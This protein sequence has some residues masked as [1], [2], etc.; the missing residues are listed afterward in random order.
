MLPVR[1]DDDDDHVLNVYN[2]VF[3]IYHIYKQDLVLTY[4]D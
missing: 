4:K 2:H 3:D 1:Y